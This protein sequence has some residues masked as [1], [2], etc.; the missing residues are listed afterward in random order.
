MGAVVV[1]GKI[2]VP[3]GRFETFENNTGVHEAY[4]PA[5]DSWQALAPLPTPRSGTATAVLGGLVLVMGGEEGAGTFEENEAYD[6]ATDFWTPLA[7]LPTPRHGI[8]AAVIDNVVYLPGGAPVVGGSRQSDANE[9][10]TLS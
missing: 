5:T 2:Y 10:F 3:G 1:G 9:A 8:G 6:P 4:D 7:P